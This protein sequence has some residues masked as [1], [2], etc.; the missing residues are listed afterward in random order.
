MLYGVDGM[1]MMENIGE[2]QKLLVGVGITEK[3][4]LGQFSK[5]QAKWLTEYIMSRY[6]HQITDDTTLLGH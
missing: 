3:C 6:R 1:N 5:E 4:P 2:F